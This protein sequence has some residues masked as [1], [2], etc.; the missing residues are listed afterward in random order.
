MCQPTARGQ[1]TSYCKPLHLW[2]L[3][4][5]KKLSVVASFCPVEGV[6]LTTSMMTKLAV[7]ALVESERTQIKGEHS[8]L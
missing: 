2:F 8:E 4:D 7:I 6:L 1:Q 5:F 3:N